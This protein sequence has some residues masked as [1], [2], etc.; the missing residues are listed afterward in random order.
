[1][2]DF[3]CVLGWGRKR[4]RIEFWW[5]YLFFKPSIKRTAI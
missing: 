2:M 3:A 5:G 1:L 4:I